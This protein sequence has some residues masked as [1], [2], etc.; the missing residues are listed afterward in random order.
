MPLEDQRSSR[1]PQV[2]PPGI[3]P[4]DEDWRGTASCLHGLLSAFLDHSLPSLRGEPESSRITSLPAL[5]DLPDKDLPGT[6]LHLPPVFLRAD[7]GEDRAWGAGGGEG[8]KGIDLLEFPV[9]CLDQ[10]R[11]SVLLKE[12][13]RRR[14]ERVLDLD[15]VGDDEVGVAPALLGG[16]A[17]LGEVDQSGAE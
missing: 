15:D 4:T 8:R 2:V 17:A 3:P 16:L 14:E 10:D 11:K 9:S 7:G 1:F 6:P 5:P 13:G 12:D